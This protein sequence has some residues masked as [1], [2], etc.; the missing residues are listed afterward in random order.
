VAPLVQVAW[1]DGDVTDRERAVVLDLAAARGVVAGTPP[2]AQLL[3]WLQ[4][5]PPAELF[6]TAIE[7]MNAGFAVLPAAE[8]AD[9]VGAVLDACER[10][11][12]ASE[13]PAVL[14]LRGSA[15]KPRFSKR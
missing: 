12:K 2:H 14:G 3:A 5:R 9:R 8:R 13:G 11:A 6:D 4:E 1:A 15:R 7:I 10:V